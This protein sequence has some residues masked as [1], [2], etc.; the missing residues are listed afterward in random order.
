MT[1]I[2]TELSGFGIIM[3]GDTAYTVE[4]ADTR[5]T[6]E[7][8][9]FKGLVKVLPVPSINAGISYWGWSTMPPGNTMHSV[10]MDWWIRDYLI[11]HFK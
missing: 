11:A 8:R 3:A 4:S 7:E 6:L 9:A 10:W 2:I 5:G 1:L